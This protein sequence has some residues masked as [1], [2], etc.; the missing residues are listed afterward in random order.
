MKVNEQKTDLC[1]FYK[2][3]VAPISIV[4]SGQVISSN[5]TINVLGVI[6]DSKLQWSDHI[7]L[8]IKKSFNA[9]NA[10]KLIKKF[11]TPKE[12]LQLITSNFYSI[13]FYNSE[14]WHL[15]SLKPPL[16]QK[17]LSASANALK[18]CWKIVDN[19]VSYESLHSL[20]KR[21]TPEQFMKYKLALSLHKLYNINYNTKEFIRLNH[22][23][24]LTSRQTKF[25][26]VK[27]NALK[28]GLNCLA[29]RL[30]VLNGKIPLQWL[31]DSITT[32]KVKCKELLL[33]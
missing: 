13:L 12:L 33:Q 14:I 27:S 18:V 25:Y 4:L 9:L 20:S 15:P 29:N 3:D 1:L 16:K 31:N 24:I 2:R 30:G 11:F 19:T 32:F 17:L 5:K 26:T 6:F 28:V 10:I 21:A 8:T 22:N 7:A 23:Q